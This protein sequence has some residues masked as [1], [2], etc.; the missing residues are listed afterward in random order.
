MSA[1]E[2]AGNKGLARNRG[3]Y[4]PRPGDAFVMPY[5]DTAGPFTGRGHIGFVLR[6]DVVEGR[7]T[8]IDTVEGNA[9]NRVKVGHRVLSDRTIVGLISQ[10]PETEQPVGWATGPGNTDVGGPDTTR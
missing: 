7:A 9:G 5:R 3:G 4:V 2:K 6:V 10:F 1:R 8:S